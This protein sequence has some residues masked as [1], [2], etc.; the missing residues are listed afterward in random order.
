M[1]KYI[2]YS[3]LSIALFSCKEDA[4]ETYDVS[5][6]R[7]VYFIWNF[8]TASSAA[9]TIIHKR[10]Y[11][12]SMRISLAGYDDNTTSIT[13]ELPLSLVGP[14]S[15]TPLR[16]KFRVNKELTTAVEGE[17]YEID[18]DSTHIPANTN[19]VYLRFKAIRSPKLLKQEVC[20][21]IDLIETEEYSIIEKYNN[22]DIW[23]DFTQVLSGRTFRVIYSEIMTQ[24]NYWRDYGVK[25]FGP[26]SAAKMKLLNSIMD[27]TY[28]DWGPSVAGSTSSPISSGVFGY[29]AFQFQK[30]LQQKADSGNPVIDEDGNYMQL[31]ADYAV[32]YTDYL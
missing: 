15:S 3:L 30:D 4:I 26:W 19:K 20:L 7:S 14:L 2:L 27:W 1:K 31:G 13:G 28:A 11:T 18:L 21:A 12:D 23:N 29:A 10:M 25:Y 5:A 9:G 24:P 16:L 32:D 22:T 17:D 8:S 6:K